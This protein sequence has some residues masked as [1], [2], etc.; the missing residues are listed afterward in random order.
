M[1]DCG[2]LDRGAESVCNSACPQLPQNFRP[3]GTAAPQAAPK[4]LE[5][6]AALLA[7]ADALT[8]LEPALRATH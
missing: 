4:Q 6:R 2:D 1:Y 3:G 8:I 7:K 5:L